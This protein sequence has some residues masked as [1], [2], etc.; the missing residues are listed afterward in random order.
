[1]IRSLQETKG[2]L[3]RLTL[4]PESN[5]EI[6]ELAR[7]CPREVPKGVRCRH[8]WEGDHLHLISEIDPDYVPE[9]E[10]TT[11]RTDSNLIIPPPS[12]EKL[13]D[14]SKAD[15]LTKA[16]ELGLEVDKDFKADEVKASLAPKIRNAWIAHNKKLDAAPPK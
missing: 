14:W 5:E 1:V 11:P 9:P 12:I 13:V 10:T 7:V 15:L 8:Q 2:G 6:A 3:G 16:A 4:R